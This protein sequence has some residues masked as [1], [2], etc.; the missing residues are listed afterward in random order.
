MSSSMLSVDFGILLG[1]AYQNF[2]DE[3]RAHLASQ[4]Y[5]D[6]GKVYG[7]VFRALEADSLHLRPLAERL[8]MTDQGASKIINE[9]QERG[10]VMRTADTQDGR[11]KKL[12]L[13][14]RGVAALAAAKDFHAQYEQRL[15]AQ[16]G[17]GAL[18][19]IRQ[20]L[21]SMVAEA[22]TDAAH[23]RLRAM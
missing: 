15:A 3:L 10:Y 12:S 18:A 22:G 17:Q 21:E 5:G 14:A 23:A 19:D 1:L 8:G 7:Y 13:S 4:G 6:V 9:M 16:W 2:V 20:T 11:V